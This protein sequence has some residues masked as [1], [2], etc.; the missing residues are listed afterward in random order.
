MGDVEHWEG[1]DQNGEAR[2][3]GN[4]GDLK[5]GDIGGNDLEKEKLSLMRNM[6][7]SMI[8]LQ[9]TRLLDEEGNKWL[10]NNKKIN[11]HNNGSDWF[12]S[13]SPM[14]EL[15]NC[16][17]MAYFC[18]L[19]CWLGNQFCSIWSSAQKNMKMKVWIWGVWL[20]VRT[21]EGR[22]SAFCGHVHGR[23]DGNIFSIH[24]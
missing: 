12:I 23:L 13:V 4:T 21:N 14:Y 19:N 2:E 6:E 15:L 24:L 1:G 16:W 7:Q 3:V 8:M 22:T 5:G 11:E 18:L 10:L 20:F 17:I 9:D